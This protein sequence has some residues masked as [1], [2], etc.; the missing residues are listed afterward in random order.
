MMD[1]LLTPQL[2]EE[3]CA[4]AAGDAF[5]GTSASS[6]L[7]PRARWLFNAVL[8]S[9]DLTR[10]DEIAILT[11]SQDVY[12]SICVSVPS[13]NYCRI[14]RAVTEATKVVVVIHEFGYAFPD[15]AAHADEWRA[16]GITII[17]DC[18]HVAGLVVDGRVVGSFG[19]YGLFSL[20]KILPTPVGGLLRTQRPLRLPALTAD[21][22]EATAMGHAALETYLPHYEYFA[23]RRRQRHTWTAAAVGAQRIHSPGVVATPFLT[24]VEQFDP[25]LTS[26]LRTK[27]HLAATLREDVWLLPTNPLVSEEVYRGALGVFET[28]A[29]DDAGAGRA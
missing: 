24:Y 17:E 28:A 11:T 12:V 8:A 1:E 20:S 13:F 25:R 19:D 9:L 15:L 10:S 14:A 22:R 3:I 16:R 7:G 23:S 21:E 29:C 18:A 6:F 4:S 27:F 2:A 5:A 26:R